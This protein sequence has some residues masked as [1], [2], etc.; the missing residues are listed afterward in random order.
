MSEKQTETR[1]YICHHLCSSQ[2]GFAIPDDEGRLCY[3][4]ACEFG[5]FVL[6]G[7]HLIDHMEGERK[8]S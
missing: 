4:C 3:R 7:K 5:H 2:Y 1:C 8:D 6:A